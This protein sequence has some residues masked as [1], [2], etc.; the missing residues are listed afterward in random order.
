MGRPPSWVPDLK[1]KRRGLTYGASAPA[2]TKSDRAAAAFQHAR[3]RHPESARTR[4]FTH[5]AQHL[6]ATYCAMDVVT[7][8]LSCIAQQ[9]SLCVS[10]P[11][12]PGLICHNYRVSRLREQVSRST[13]PHSC[14]R[15]ASSAARPQARLSLHRGTSWLRDRRSELLERRSAAPLLSYASRLCATR[16]LCSAPRTS[17]PLR[18]SASAIARV[19]THGP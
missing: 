6:S 12:K 18:T 16:R 15:T 1:L 5:K 11:W 8:S 13:G 2:P 4:A 9:A 7:R 19:S 17:Y 14:S 10:R 3:R